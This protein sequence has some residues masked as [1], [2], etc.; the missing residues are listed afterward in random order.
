MGF[1]QIDKTYVNVSHIVC[2]ERV[3]GAYN[4]CITL[5][6]GIGIMSK[7]Y[8]KSIINKIEKAG[9]EVSR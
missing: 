2:I 1:I 8:P 4:T 5:E 3:K 9:K 7:S 6:N